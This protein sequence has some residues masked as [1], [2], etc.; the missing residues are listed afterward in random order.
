M[1][2]FKKQRKGEFHASFDLYDDRC[3]ARTYVTETMAMVIPGLPE[4]KFTNIQ[5]IDK[6]TRSKPQLTRVKTKESM[7]HRITEHIGEKLNIRD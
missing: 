5:E 4:N 3:S 1:N 7:A 6:D 2:R